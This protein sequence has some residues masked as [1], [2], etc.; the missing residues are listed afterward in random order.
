MLVY[1]FSYC[2]FLASILIVHGFYPGLDSWV[3]YVLCVCD[4]Y[5]VIKNAQH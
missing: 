2:Y 4:I 3:C 1:L 5:L